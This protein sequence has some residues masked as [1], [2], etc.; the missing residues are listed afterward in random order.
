MQYTSTPV[1]VAPPPQQVPHY[2]TDA[3]DL[4][5]WHLTREDW[6]ACKGGGN[7]LAKQ[8][9]HVRRHWISHSELMFGGLQLLEDG[10]CVPKWCRLT[11]RSTQMRSW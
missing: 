6:P 5:V 4:N 9:E 10:T 8:P 2:T 11:S 7:C 1:T 3:M